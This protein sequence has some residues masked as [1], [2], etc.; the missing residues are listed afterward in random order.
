V[1]LP[2]IL[3]IAQ[4]LARSVHFVYVCDFVHKN[5]RPET[6]VILRGDD[7]SPHGLAYLLGFDRF[8][9]IDN[10]TMRAGDTVLERNL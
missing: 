1:N 3:H 6:I 10:Q 4:S 2:R 7:T 9:D 5:I 8:R